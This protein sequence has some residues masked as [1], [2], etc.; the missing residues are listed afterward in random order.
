LAYTYNWV[1]NT[2]TVQRD[3][4][5]GDGYE[6]DESRQ[7]TGFKQNGTVNAAAGIVTTPANSMG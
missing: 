7:I 6:Y 2:T 5:Q 4:G 1:N 3:N